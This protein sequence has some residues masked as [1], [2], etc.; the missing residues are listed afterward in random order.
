MRHW[1][2]ARLAFGLVVLS[3][4]SVLSLATGTAHAAKKPPA[5]YKIEIEATPRSLRK[6]LEEHLD[7]ARFAKR[8]DISEDQFDFLITAT[9]QQ[10]RDLAAT[11]GYF[12]PVVGPRR[13]PHAAQTCAPSTIRN[14]S[15]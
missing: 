10:V 12:T 3:V 5:S 1:L 8:P 9:P 2:R 14:G 15:P 6:L 11:Q 7:I 4:L 13:G